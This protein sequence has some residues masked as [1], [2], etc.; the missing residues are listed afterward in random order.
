VGAGEVVRRPKLRKGGHLVDKF[1]QGRKGRPGP[2]HKC[3]ERITHLD[4]YD[5]YPP[6]CTAKGTFML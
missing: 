3:L 4:A 5:I 2:F 1:K 6:A